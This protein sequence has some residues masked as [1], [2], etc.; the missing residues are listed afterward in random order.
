MNSQNSSK[1]ENKRKR[2]PLFSVKYLVFDFVKIT[3]MVPMLLFMRPVIKYENKAARKRMRGGVIAFSNHTS[4]Q[5]PVQLLCTIWYRRPYFMAMQELFNSKFGNWIFHKF[6]CIPVDRKNFNFDSFYE[7]KD[8]VN[9]GMVCVVFSEGGIN[10]DPTKVNP[11]KP[12][13]AVLAAV[14]RAPLVPMYIVPRGS[15]WRTSKIMIGEEIDPDE[16][17]SENPTIEEL[18]QASEILH[19]RVLDLKKLYEERYVNKKKNGKAAK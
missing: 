2:S 3:A 19:Q 1:N 5:N 18:E 10:R 8:A 11:F 9:S 12:G 15:N 13:T 16:I 14:T 4:L 7:M 6:L 17:L